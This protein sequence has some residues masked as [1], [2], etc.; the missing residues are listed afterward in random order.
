MKCNGTVTRRIVVFTI[1]LCPSYHC[2]KYC[3]NF[4]HSLLLSQSGKRKTKTHQI[5]YKVLCSF[6]Q[7]FQG[8]IQFI[9]SAVTAITWPGFGVLIP[10]VSTWSVYIQEGRLHGF[11]WSLCEEIHYTEM[12]VS[13]VSGFIKPRQLCWAGF[14]VM[15][16]CICVSVCV[17]VNKISQKLFNQATSFLVGAF[18]LT[19]G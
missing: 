7:E 19:Q 13:A 1:S 14:I 12:E 6:K 16:M 18:P 2:K 8:Q 3:Q 17:S 9:S 10:S 15:L 4:Y 11:L 5:T